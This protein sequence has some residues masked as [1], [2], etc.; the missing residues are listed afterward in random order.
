M[1]LPDVQKL[2]MTVELFCSTIG[3]TALQRHLLV[4]HAP[5]LECAVGAGSD[6]LRIQPPSTPSHVKAIQPEELEQEAVNQLGY[7][8]ATPPMEQLLKLIQGLSQEVQQLESR[9]NQQGQRRAKVPGSCFKS[10]QEGHWRKD[11]GRQPTPPTTDITTQAS[12][13]VG[14]PQQ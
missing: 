1:G 2:E 13:N 7:N 8:Q 12:G 10:G 9:V 5:D 6:Y 3:N 11:C 4:V 14:R